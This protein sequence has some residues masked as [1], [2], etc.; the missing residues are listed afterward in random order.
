MSVVLDTP[1]K[2][3]AYRLLVLKAAMKLELVGMRHSS[4]KSVC[5]DVKRT[6]GFKA[7]RGDKQ[8]IFDQ[9][10]T[11]LREKGVLV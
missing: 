9:Y 6:Y 7:K 2:I 1:S 5:A 4:G 11:M 8:A 10:C 3:E